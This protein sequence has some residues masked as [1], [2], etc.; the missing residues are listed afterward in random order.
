MEKFFQANGPKKQAKVA[1]LI[2]NKV[3]FQTKVIKKS[4]EEHFILIKGESTNMK[5][6][7]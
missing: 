1:T 6:Q 2:W 4:A 5:S 7:F 3:D